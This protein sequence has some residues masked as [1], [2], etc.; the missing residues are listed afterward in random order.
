M[1]RPADGALHDAIAK[2]LEERAD[3]RRI[4]AIA[5]HTSKYR[6]SVPIEDLILT[7]D[8]GQRIELVFKDLGGSGSST[9]KR[10]EFAFEPRRSI[11]LHRWLLESRSSGT[12]EYWGSVEQP[13]QGR[14]WLF[15]ERATG[16]PL[17]EA[18]FSSWEAAAEW[19]GGF[20]A[21][22]RVRLDELVDMPLLRYDAA[23]YRVWMERALSFVLGDASRRTRIQRLAG[24]HELV[25]ERLLSMPDTLIHGDFHASNVLVDGGPE[26]RQVCVLDWELA[27]IGPGLLDLAALTSGNWS[28]GERSRLNVAYLKGLAGSPNAMIAADVLPD[29]LAVCRLQHAIQLLGWSDDWAPPPD[30]VRDWL[31]EAEHLVSALGLEEP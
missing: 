9:V 21:A 17:D 26:Q 27:G 2:L 20:H 12:P 7:V 3:P 10:P 4:V 30:Q 16:T 15:L 14:F 31:T 6:S 8:D 29:A 11:Y 22:M 5:R 24:Y 18:E 28:D 23:Y 1:G 25:V 13:S 19:L